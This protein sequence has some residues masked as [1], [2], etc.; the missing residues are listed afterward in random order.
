VGLRVIRSLTGGTAGYYLADL[1]D[2]QY[3]YCGLDLEGVDKRLSE[4]LPSDQ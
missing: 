2:R 3:Y 1:G 4:L